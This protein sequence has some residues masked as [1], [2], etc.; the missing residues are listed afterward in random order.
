MTVLIT[1]DTV[2]T[3]IS[4]DDPLYD[5]CAFDIICGAKDL[6]EMSIAS[7]ALN[8]KT[9]RIL[10]SANM[11]DLEVMEND[12]CSKYSISFKIRLSL[13]PAAFSAYQNLSN[14][15]EFIGTVKEFSDRLIGY[16]TLYQ[17][18]L[19]NAEICPI[20]PFCS[21]ML[22]PRPNRIDNWYKSLPPE[23]RRPALESILEW[24][25]DISTY[26][27][28]YSFLY[29]DGIDSMIE[30]YQAGVPIEDIVA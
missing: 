24:A 12:D 3:E 25:S 14:D 4:F 28:L 22:D 2:H 8:S 16:A 10:R 1:E 11:L 5:L 18:A 23:H 21:K 27:Q 9:I 6:A 7:S 20:E 30:A 15:E 26:C 13:T 19:I 17:E 29:D